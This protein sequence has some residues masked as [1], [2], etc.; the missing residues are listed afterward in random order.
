MGSG[1]SSL[2]TATLAYREIEIV[3]T[4]AYDPKVWQRSY[5]V[6]ARR[7]FPLESLITH[8]LP[9][10]E[11]AHGIKLMESRQ[12]LKIMFTPIWA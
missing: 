9:L 10:E 7:Q 11:V 4:R 3:G 12:G 2:N 8:R 1:E 5:D 6:L